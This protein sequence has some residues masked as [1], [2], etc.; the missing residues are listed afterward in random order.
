MGEPPLDSQ[1]W[2]ANGLYLAASQASVSHYQW[3]ISATTVSGQQQAIVLASLGG[4][5]VPDT[6]PTWWET[7]KTQSQCEPFGQ[8]PGTITVH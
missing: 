4:L 3:H 7:A 6:W 1:R 5:A 2:L 8:A